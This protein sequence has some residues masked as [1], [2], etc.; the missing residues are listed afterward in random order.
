VL[1]MGWLLARVRGLARV[2][3]VKPS[4][5]SQLRARGIGERGGGDRDCRSRISHRTPR[6]WL[7]RQDRASQQAAGPSLVR[8][9]RRRGLRRRLTSRFPAPAA[10]WAA[11]V[12]TGPCTWEWFWRVAQGAE[13]GWWTPLE[14]R[15]GNLQ[16]LGDSG[17][18]Y[19]VASCVSKGLGASRGRRTE[20]SESS[21]SPRQRRERRGKR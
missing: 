19:G 4:R 14:G 18:P 12:P 13:Y 1:R 17:V 9:V 16:T 8:M 11:S 2:A 6:G 5:A 15:F 20:S 7:A 21:E 3:G 10:R